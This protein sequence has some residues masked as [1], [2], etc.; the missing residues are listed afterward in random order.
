VIADEGAGVVRDR[1]R[2]AR[3]PQPLE[4][5]V[6]GQA[7]VERQRALPPDRA[8]PAALLPRVDVVIDVER[9]GFEGDP[10]AAGR[11]AQHQDRP[12]P[13]VRDQPAELPRGA[14]EVHRQHVA[15][16]RPGDLAARVD[17]MAS[18][19]REARQEDVHKI[20]ICDNGGH[21]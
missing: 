12:R 21:V 15:A 11:E 4:D 13:L 3:F 5:A 10:R 20:T 18:P 19:G 14:V 16:Q 7:H 1:R 8:A 17:P 2:H 9:D 6:Q